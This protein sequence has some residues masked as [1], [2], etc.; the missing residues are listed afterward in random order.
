MNLNSIGNDSILLNVRENYGFDI[1][2]RF[3]LCLCHPFSLHQK[4]DER[5]LK[6]PECFMIHLSNSKKT[7]NTNESF[8]INFY[9]SRHPT[10][11]HMAH[12]D[13]VGSDIDYSDRKNNKFDYRIGI[14]FSFFHTIRMGC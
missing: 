10:P 11:N 6:C 1:F 3:L 8:S 9:M 4:G 2:V 13:A 14:F 5:A 12:I 7:L